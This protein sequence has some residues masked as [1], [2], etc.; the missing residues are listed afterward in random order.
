MS[1]TIPTMVI[2]C[3]VPTF[4][5]GTFYHPRLVML[6]V[7]G[8]AGMYMVH[9]LADDYNTYQSY[10]RPAQRLFGKRSIPE[11][12]FGLRSNT[13]PLSE[14]AVVCSHPTG[15]SDPSQNANPLI[16]TQMPQASFEKRLQRN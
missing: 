9:L 6:M 3:A 11:Q 14:K 4:V 5:K 16:N 7:A 8:L 12:V 13:T 2:L 1:R 15:S 10:N